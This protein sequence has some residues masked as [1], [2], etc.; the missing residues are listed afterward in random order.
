MP[1]GQ[2][3]H[4]MLQEMPIF[5][6]AFNQKYL[7]YLESGHIPTE[8]KEACNIL[9][10]ENGTSDDPATFRPIT[11]GAVPLKAFTIYLCYSLFS[12]LK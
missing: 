10:H 11:L 9:L 12:F 6:I 4:N 2:D 3:I 5:T 1:L 7:S 8:W